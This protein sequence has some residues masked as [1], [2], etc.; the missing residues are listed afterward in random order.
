MMLTIGLMT[1]FLM[2][3]FL[4]T[5]FSIRRGFGLARALLLAAVLA[6]TDPV[7]ASDV[8]LHSGQ[9]RNRMRFSLPAEGGLNDGI[10][11]PFVLLALEL[12]G[13]H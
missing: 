2:T 6:L 12:L 1:A 3:A 13:A 4:M 11:L 5:A 7:L 9:D 10:L 8:E